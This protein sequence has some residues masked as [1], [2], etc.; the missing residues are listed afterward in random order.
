MRRILL[1]LALS[2][3]LLFIFF[4]A[5]YIRDHTVR[6][7]TPGLDPGKHISVSPSTGDPFHPLRLTECTGT[8]PG[9]YAPCLA[10]TLPNAVSAEEMIYPAFTISPPI[11]AVS[12]PED[13][14]RWWNNTW[15]LWDRAFKIDGRLRYPE[16]HG[17]V[18]VFR[19]V[20]LSASTPFDQW[21]M[22]SCMSSFAPTSHVVPSSSKPTHDSVL[23]ANIPDSWS[24]QHFLDRGMRV[25]AQS[26]DY[27]TQYVATGREG[28]K[29]VKELWSS[30][31]YPADQ[32]LHG[33]TSFVA[34][35][36]IWSCR[37]PLI[38]PWLTQR[39]LSLLS[40]DDLQPVE[41]SARKLILYMTRSNGLTLNAGRQVL[42]EDILLAD[43]QSL[44][45]KRG[46]REKLKIFNHEDFP[47]TDALIRYIHR[48]VKAVVGPHGSALHNHLW[49]A[50]DTLL[51]EFMP[52]TRP[53]F[54][55]YEGARMRDQPY[56]VLMLDPVDEKHNMEVDVPALLD[57]LS[58]RL[59]QPLEMGE[60]V[61]VAYDWEAE[62]LGVN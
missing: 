25:V 29:S 26:R 46:K 3:L 5:K 55:F 34:A 21:T 28:H 31:G 48:N 53:D 43:I 13:A 8:T 18:Y 42:N 44:L 27:Q 4:K 10:R 61:K 47:S 2:I 14:E 16:K 11:F 41:K 37:A 38:H 56:A 24:L 12:R 22:Q 36:L 58:E 35:Q 59:D 23:L 19:N 62:E 39:A 9:Y 32:V 6:I 40:P 45:D 33:E 60:R 57:I 49:A 1:P 15:M 20:T 50:E 51:V 7:V 17:Q 30:L 52:T 54:T